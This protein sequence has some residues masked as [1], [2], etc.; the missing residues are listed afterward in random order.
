MERKANKIKA[1]M[2]GHAVA[3]ALGVPVEFCTR[4]EL[5][6][7]PV[8]DMIGWG[9]YPVPE[10]CWSDD[11]SMS[12]A[13]LDSLASGSINY[14]EIMQNFV[15]WVSRHEFTPTGEMF[16]IGKTCLSAIRKY[17][18][19]DDIDAL[20]CGLDTERSNGNGSLMRIHP[21]ALFLYYNGLAD[22]RYMEVIHNA[23]ALTHAHER[24]KIACGIYTFVLW[25]L[26]AHPSKGAVLKGLC[27][28]SR[29]YN[30]SAEII[31]YDR[32]LTYWMGIMH[33]KAVDVSEIKSTGYV[34]D[35][36]EAAIWSLLTTRDY[37]SAVLRAVNLG[38]DTDTVAAVTG[39][40][41]GALYGETSIPAHWLDTLKKREY[42]ESLCERAEGSWCGG[43]EK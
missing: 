39:G 40:L 9:S 10:G 32:L 23:S 38:E 3:D 28:A 29:F 8:T 22:E 12:L 18:Q 26:L 6:D 20:S 5:S 24:S 35:T 37:A 19:D 16:D 34:V 43:K 30:S 2:L 14:D 11:T 31:H 33:G 41:A 1:V 15:G 7:A 36:L 4:E 25:E 27:R 21:F 13:A 42:I 17:L